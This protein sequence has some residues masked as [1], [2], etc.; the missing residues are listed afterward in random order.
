[1]TLE[2]AQALRPP[3]TA[4][5]MAAAYRCCLKRERDRDRSWRATAQGGFESSMV[6]VDQLADAFEAPD[7]I[8]AFSDG[9]AGAAAVRA[10]DE[11]DGAAEYARRL[12]RALNRL[13]SAPSLQRTLRLIVKNGSNRKES[14]WELM[15]RGRQPGGQRSPST[16]LTAKNC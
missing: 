1:M 5:Q 8:A 15:S 11:P 2:E 6:S 7:E 4:G 13:R 10:F 12:K 3:Y 14:V 9:G 16:K